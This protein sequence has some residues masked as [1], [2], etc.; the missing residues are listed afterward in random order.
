MQLTKMETLRALQARRDSGFLTNI[1][2]TQ[3]RNP[4]RKLRGLLTLLNA[5]HTV[6]VGQEGRLIVN[7]ELRAWVE[8]EMSA[9]L[10][11]SSTA[12]TSEVK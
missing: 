8:L 6:T 12:R 2:L 7:G 10:I 4:A 11:L 3:H 1:I 5:G 9:D